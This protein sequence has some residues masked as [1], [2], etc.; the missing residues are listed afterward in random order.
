MYIT[1]RSKNYFS[2][3]NNTQENAFPAP[4]SLIM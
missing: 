1:L 4:D 2:V 3:V